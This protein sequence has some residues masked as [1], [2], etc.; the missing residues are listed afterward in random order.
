MPVKSSRNLFRRL[1]RTALPGIIV[2]NYP[3]VNV[4]FL[5]ESFTFLPSQD[6]KYSSFLR[7]PVVPSFSSTLSAKPVVL[8]LFHSAGRPALTEASP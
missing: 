4:K 6:L 1:Y 7:E 8:L 5:A 3:R 2:L